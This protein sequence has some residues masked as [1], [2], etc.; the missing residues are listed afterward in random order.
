MSAKRKRRQP[1]KPFQVFV[2]HATYDK[3]V[4]RVLCEKLEQLGTTTFRDDRD[5]SGGDLIPDAIR[6]AIESCN[7]FVV[8]LSPQSIRRQWVLVEIGM[9][10][11]FRKRIVP[12]MF[13][14]PAE[15]LPDMIDKSR[16]FALDDF[17][18]YLR[19][20]ETRVAANG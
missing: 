8:L 11:A 20:L 15:Q 5:I 9:A 2:S 3:W 14:I 16:G 13:H 10:L 17:D 7:E 4:A 19:D 18:G 6:D 1:S 12:L